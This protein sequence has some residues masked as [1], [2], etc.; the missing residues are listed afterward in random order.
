MLF[1][2]ALL[3]LSLQ[4]VVA[5]RNDADLMSFMTVSRALTFQM[6][7]PEIADTV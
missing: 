4:N 5:Q 2:A 1:S 6:T 3:L 7:T